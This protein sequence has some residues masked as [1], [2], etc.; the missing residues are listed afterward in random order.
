MLEESRRALIAS[1]SGE[2]WSWV[3]L[4]GVLA[5][6]GVSIV[7]DWLL[8][9]QPWKAAE[10]AAPCNPGGSGGDNGGQ[11]CWALLLLPVEDERLGPM[12]LLRCYPGLSGPYR[13]PLPLTRW[14]VW[15]AS[16]GLTLAVGALLLVGGII[17]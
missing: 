1:R 11:R 3:L 15:L 14:P 2:G 8:P 6:L 9:V 16:W 5:A 7:A 13:S 4:L 10:I 12:Q 17:R